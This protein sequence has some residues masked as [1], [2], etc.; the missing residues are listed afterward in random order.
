MRICHVCMLETCYVVFTWILHLF[1]FLFE[2]CHLWTLSL[3]EWN[4]HRAVE[5]S[6]REIWALNCTDEPH[7]CLCP[8]LFSNAVSCA[9]SP[10]CWLLP[11][12]ATPIKSQFHFWSF[13]SFHCIALRQEDAFIIVF[14][15]ESFNKLIQ[16]TNQYNIV[17]FTETFQFCP[18]GDDL[19]FKDLHRT[20]LQILKYW[21]WMT[22][23]HRTHS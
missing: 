1:L 19:M 15:T 22:A 20:G 21:L 12:Q 9:A 10:P 17:Y 3:E 6:I 4:C 7:V 5:I 8:C 14:V 11:T 13:C 18:S 16:R 2:R 23:W